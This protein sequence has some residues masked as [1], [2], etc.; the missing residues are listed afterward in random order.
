MGMLKI[1]T[2]GSFG[3]NYKEFSA[4]QNGHAHA[5]REAI[6]YLVDDVL[7]EAINQ[8]HQLQEQGHKPSQ[9][10]TVGK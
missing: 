8:D 3:T 1:E 10:F 2:H 9:G 4:M 6:A 7:K 5:V